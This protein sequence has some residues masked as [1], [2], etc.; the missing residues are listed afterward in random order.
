[1]RCSAE[2]PFDGITIY[3]SNRIQEV[4]SHELKEYLHNITDKTVK[5]RDG[6]FK[7]HKPEDLYEK[8]ASTRVSDMN[9]RKNKEPLPLEI[10]LEKKII[11]GKDIRG[12]LYDGWKLSKLIFELLPEKEYEQHVIVVTDRLIGTLEKGDARYHVR[13]V[14]NSL[15]SI[16][17]TSGIVEGP[18]KP[19]EY[20]LGVEKD[21]EFKPMEYSD[22]RMTEA[23]HSY[24]LQ[25]VF[26]RLTGDPFCGKKGC[27]LFNSH[28]QEEV[29][30]NQVNG[31]LCEGHKKVLSTL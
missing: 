25:T 5:I 4:N 12:V 18:A 11:Q 2:F 22:N 23:V 31:S 20:Y 19:K 3:L 8:I 16:I 17:S 13:A 10:G 28:W 7:E 9:S 21:F 27:P 14:I 26:W 1:M 24:A 15:P 30:K 29:I 6:F